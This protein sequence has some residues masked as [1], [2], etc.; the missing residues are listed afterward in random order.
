ME[1]LLDYL[2]TFVDAGYVFHL[3]QVSIPVKLTLPPYHQGLDA[4]GHC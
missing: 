4:E 3:Q 2:S 1:G